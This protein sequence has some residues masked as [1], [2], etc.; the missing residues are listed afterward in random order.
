MS[1]LFAGCDDVLTWIADGGPLLEPWHFNL[2]E[3]VPELACTRLACGQRSLPGWLKFLRNQIEFLLRRWSSFFRRWW[4]FQSR[5]S[6]PADTWRHKFLD[7]RVLIRNGQLLLG[8][9]PL[10]HPLRI[11]VDPR[12]GYNPLQSFLSNPFRRLLHSNVR[13]IPETKYWIWKHESRGG[14]RPSEII[15]VAEY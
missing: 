2:Q 11:C 3:N 13:A 4:T 10:I 15:K 7:F 8:S 6:V 14:L 9:D 5:L 1:I 12:S